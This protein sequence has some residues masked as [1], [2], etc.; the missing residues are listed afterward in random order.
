MVGDEHYRHAGGAVELTDG[1]HDLRPADGVQHGGGL[2]QH[3]AAGRHSDDT[4]NGHPL[5]LSA[6]E[7]VGGVL[8]VLVHAHGLEGVV[9]PPADLRR[10]HPQILRGEGHVLLH[11]VGNDLVVRVL[12]Y[13][14]HG[15]ADVQ[16]FILVGGVDAVHV[17][18]AAGGQQDGVQV[19]GQGGLAGAVVP[20]HSHE[21]A[22]LDVQAY[23]VQHKG[24][25]R[26]LLRIGEAE[27]LCLNDCMVHIAHHSL[28]GGPAARS[29]AGE[30][31]A[32]GGDGQAQLLALGAAAVPAGYQSLQQ[33]GQYRGG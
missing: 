6:G 1:L 25:D 10:G 19:L 18:F 23:P 21:G 8:P 32:G 24:V 26:P 33:V 7:Q 5:F 4:G 16:Q 14:A 9:H 20:Q 28:F 11:H 22:L 15:A 27:P 2:V 17:D 29:P 30:G 31:Q 13:H 12:E 3:N